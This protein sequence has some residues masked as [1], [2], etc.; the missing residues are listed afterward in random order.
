M[1]RK[2]HEIA[3]AAALAAL[4]VACSPGDRHGQAQAQTR[5]ERVASAASPDQPA[6]ADRYADQNNDGRVTRDEARG[7]PALAAS[8]DRYDRN[9]DG[10]LDRAEFA[11]LEAHAPGEDERAQ[12]RPRR[13]FPRPLD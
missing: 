1:H 12:L 2:L 6:G 3:G 10:Q 11:R 7:D 13:E 8:F 4:C 5:A 9:R